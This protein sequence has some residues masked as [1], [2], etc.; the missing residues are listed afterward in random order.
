VKSLRRV[1][2]RESLALKNQIVSSPEQEL[3][4]RILASAPFH[5]SPRSSELLRYLG[6]RYFSG[7]GD[8]VHEA[9]IGQELFGRGRDFDP[10]ADSIVRASIRQLRSRL[11]EFY[12]H[13][14]AGEVIALVIPKGEYRLSFTPRSPQPVDPLPA[15]SP[16]APPPRTLLI[17]LAFIAVAAASFLLGAHLRPATPPASAQAPPPSRHSV[18]EHFLNATTG[19]VHFVPSDSVVNLIQSLTSKQLSFEDYRSRLAFDP[20]RVP[21]GIDPEHWRSLVTRELL[22]IGDASIAL[23]ALRDY[24]HHAQRFH[25]LQ[26][27]DLQLRDLR[28]GNYIFLGSVAAN[29]WVSVFEPHLNFIYDN[30]F[31][32]PQRGWKNSAPLD[33]EQPWYAPAPSSPEAAYRSFAQVACLPNLSRSGLVLL[34]AGNS[35]PNTEAAGEFVLAPHSATTLAS[36]LGVPNLQD[37]PAFDILLATGQSGNAW[38]V[39]KVAAWR[40]LRDGAPPSPTTP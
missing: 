26:S 8:P 16:S 11:S 30:H 36:A 28:S 1:L 13:D 6:E 3:L 27:R 35:Q 38:R 34:I 20:A 21:S 7:S 15:P 17:L 25:F 10:S 4:S 24:P 33:G 32:G 37:S 2:G 31:R 12:D 5:R 23:R 19:P 29:P 14:G 9:Q 39:N 18:L 22:N 40:I